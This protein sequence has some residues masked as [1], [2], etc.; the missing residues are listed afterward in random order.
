MTELEKIDANMKTEHT[1]A[2]EKA[3]EFD[4]YDVEEAPFSL[5]GV[6]REG[7]SFVRLPK[8]VA[9]S[10]SKGVEMLYSY[11]TGGRVRFMTDSREIAIA[12]KL[13]SK[14]PDSRSAL[15]AI[16]GLDLYADDGGFERYFGTLNP[17][18]NYTGGFEGIFTPFP[19]DKLRTVTVNLPRAN[20]VNKLYIGIK[21]GSRLFAAEP[22][23][24]PPVVYYGSSITQGGCSSRPGT[25]YYSIVHRYINY[26]YINLGFSGNAR[27]EDE[28]IDYISSL[29]MSMFV[30]DYDHN[31]PT[32]E[33]LTKT[34]YKGYKKIREAHPDIPIL[35][36]SRPKFYLNAD[37]KARLEVIRETYRKA[38][39]E[40]DRRIYLI[41]GPDMIDED[42]REES[43]IDHCHPT[44]CGFLSMARHIIPVMKEALGLQ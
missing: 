32:V 37:D 2:P 16:T 6:F 17:P 41:E 7:D 1:I 4:F 3:A 12:I 8:T 24:E 11:T 20:T 26:D 13:P 30:F 40:N 43:L 15:T 19:S 29:D 28:I 35:L 18:L 9:S 31:A 39:A 21:K 22:F 23:S 38:L 14:M 25:A 42:T 34:H 10:V 36:L 44:D 27:G 5:H 33:H